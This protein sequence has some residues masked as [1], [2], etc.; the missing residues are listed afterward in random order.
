MAKRRDAV[1]G[2]IVSTEEVYNENLSAL[3]NS[4]QAVRYAAHMPRCHVMCFFLDVC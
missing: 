4:F 1:M 3:V 2:E